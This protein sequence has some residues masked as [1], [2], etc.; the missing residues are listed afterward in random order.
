MD[1]AHLVRR[2][3]DGNVDAFVALT[4]RFQHLA[5]GSALALVHDFQLAEDITQEAFITAWSALPKLIDPNAFPGWIRS[6]VR[7]HAFRALRRPGLNVVPLTEA[8]DIASEEAAPDRVL[9][10]RQ[11]E[12]AALAAIAALP[13][14]LREPA[15]LFF[16]H[17]CSQ[18]D[19][20][21]FLHLPI[22]TV[23]NRLHAARM[24]LKQRMLTMVESTLQSHGLPDDFANRIGRLISAS[25]SRVDA[26]FDPASLPDLLTELL[27]SDEAS[28]RA[29]PVQV[30]Q[31]PGGGI[32]RGLAAMPIASLRSGAT[33]LSSGRQT[34]TQI[35]QIGFEH[36]AP[37]LAGQASDAA[38]SKTLV[39][40]GIKVIDVMC[41]LMA[42]GS[43]AIAGEPGA[44]ALVLMEELARR[45]SDRRIPMSLFVVMPPFS[46]A[47]PASMQDGFS[48]G[49]SLKREGYSEGTIGTV[50]TFFLRGQE[51]PWTEDQLSALKAADVVIHLSREV[52]K[53]QLYPA[54]DPRTCCSCLL[55]TKLVD[56]GHLKVV[57][58]VRDALAVLPWD[59]GHQSLASTPVA[60]TRAWKL[61][62]FFT[63]PF[64]AAECYTRRPGS[65]VCLHDAVQACDEIIRGQHDDIPLEAF[66]FAGT[67]AEIRQ[68]IGRGSPTTCL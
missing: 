18:Q 64:F 20:A 33:V 13:A 21:I 58:R 4:H 31:R 14:R 52:A 29:V 17:E 6:I 40:T 23:N 8:A 54:V 30:V 1:L 57:E 10:H 3:S 24:Q 46:P 43:V 34:E 38:G 7:H 50:Q 56:D 36:V 27:V 67:M 63:Q 61:M 11:Q 16:V 47:W 65:H 53:A 35:H 66:C 55:E 60:V 5:F 68:Q 37:L 59:N 41:P 22:T 32:V 26:L 2:A 25:G 12:A 48:L 44:G 49:D 45:L 15:T 51:K 28:K 62:N 9:E 39:E 42:G 19:I